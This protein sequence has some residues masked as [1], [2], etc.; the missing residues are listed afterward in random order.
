[1]TSAP[2]LRHEQFLRVF[3]A[4]EQAVRAFVRSPIPNI[5]DS[6]DVMQE[7]TLVLW[8]KFAKHPTGG[9]FRRWACL[10]VEAPAEVRFESAERLRVL[11]GQCGY[12][13]CLVYSCCSRLRER[14]H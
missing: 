7:V 9:D 5:A 13:G 4:S 12:R 11:R 3:M 10:V 2:D 6:N 8:E 1:M 14:M